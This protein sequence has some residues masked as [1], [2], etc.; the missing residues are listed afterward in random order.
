MLNKNVDETKLPEDLK[1]TTINNTPKAELDEW[2]KKILEKETASYPINVK[3]EL[4]P[5]EKLALDRQA[6]DRGMTTEQVVAAVVRG[7]L[8]GRIG[9]PT[10]TGPSW[11]KKVKAPTGWINK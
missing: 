4:N 3:L 7:F 11:S 10:I 9:K 8:A 5:A 1:G 2:E 6:D